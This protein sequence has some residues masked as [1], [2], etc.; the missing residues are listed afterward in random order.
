M[1]KLV[2][3][4]GSVFAVF[5]GALALADAP[6]QAGKLWGY[7]NY[8][9]GWAGLSAN[10][11]RWVLVVAAIVVGLLAWDVPRRLWPRK[12]VGL[13]LVIRSARYGLGEGQYSDVTAAVRALVVDGRLNIRAD[14]KT[15]GLDPFPGQ[16][17]HLVVTYSIGGNDPQKLIVGERGW[18]VIPPVS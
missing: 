2:R 5:V 3:I 15:L 8:V 12:S 16:R 9:V 11:G 13:L 17:K 18:A 1:Q 10:G 6:E 4:G 7:W 14:N